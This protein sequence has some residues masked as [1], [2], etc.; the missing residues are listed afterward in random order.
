MGHYKSNMRDLQ[1]KHTYYDKD[2]NVTDVC[3]WETKKK[4]KG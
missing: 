4:A 1:F 2:G 3:P